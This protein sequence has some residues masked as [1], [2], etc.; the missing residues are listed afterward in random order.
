MSTRSQFVRAAKE[1]AVL[2]VAK[3]VV[4]EIVY[5]LHFNGCR[6]INMNVSLAAAALI[7]G[8]RIA[9]GLFQSVYQLTRKLT[10]FRGRRLSCLSVPFRH[11]TDQT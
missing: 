9:I 10:S 6:P 2:A 5:R 7:A 3:M 8:H 4:S 11:S 1:A